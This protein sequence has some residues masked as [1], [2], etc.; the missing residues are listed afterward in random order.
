M[1][2]KS[3]R[4]HRLKWITHMITTDTI[5]LAHDGSRAFDAYLARPA[6]GTAPSIVIFTEMFGVARHN[7]EM[8]DSYARRGF[9]ALVP[10][11]FWRSPY[12]GELAFERP[13][14]DAAW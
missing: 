8:A 1:C 9:N 12:P 4:A 7:R 6:A 11:L 5:A 14:R 10:N 13:D 3:R 2:A